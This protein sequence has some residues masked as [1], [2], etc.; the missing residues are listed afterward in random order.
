[1]AISAKPVVGYLVSMAISDNVFMGGAMVTDAFGLPMEFRYTEPVKATKLQRVLYGEVLE[2][3]IQTDV[4][5]ANILDNLEQK[6]PVFIVSDPQ[7]LPAVEAKGRAAI[8]LGESRAAPLAE[9]G[10]TTTVAEDEVL[11]Q[12]TSTGS[13]VRVRFSVSPARPDSSGISRA[14]RQ[15]ELLKVLVDAGKSMDVLE[16]MRRVDKALKMLW[17]EISEISA[18][19]VAG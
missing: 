13:P 7:F 1:M 14:S 8:W 6:P 17:D 18:G 11:V 12:L 16:P 9:V 2:K 10:A 3:Y 15:A 4:I 5:L 19:N